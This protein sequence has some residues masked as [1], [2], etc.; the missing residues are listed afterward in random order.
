MR[1]KKDKTYTTR[2]IKTELARGFKITSP[3]RIY[4]A[5]K[6]YRYEVDIFVSLIKLKGQKE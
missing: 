2:V 6:M 1:E 5:A 3:I 4:Y